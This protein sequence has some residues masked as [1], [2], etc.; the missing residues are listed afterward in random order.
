MAKNPPARSVNG[1]VRKSGPAIEPKPDRFSNPLLST[2]AIHPDLKPLFEEVVMVSVWSQAIA[3]CYSDLLV[4]K[5]SHRLPKADEWPDSLGLERKRAHHA[6][7]VKATREQYASKGESVLVTDFVEPR[8]TQ[9]IREWSGYYRD[10]CAAI[11]KAKELAKSPD[12]SAIMDAGESRPVHRWTTQT[13]IDLDNLAVT[14]H[15]IQMGGADGLGFIRRGLPPMPTNFRSCAQAVG[16]RIR[17]LRSIPVDDAKGRV[18][19][20]GSDESA[21]P[22]L[23]ENQCRVLQTMALFDASR[24]LSSKMIAEE[25]PPAF[26]LSV[27]TVRQCVGKL[28][29]SN[30]AERPEGNRRGAR[31]NTAGRRLVGKIA[32]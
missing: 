20:A 28:I 13:I 17:E 3:N 9:C 16:K 21:G 22:A 27:E 6:E 15:P 7:W 4:L 14:L 8:W 1:S 11:A 19:R 26:R 5:E 2:P 24:L 18:L 32:D 30:L 23:T 12:V 29:E 25:M 31:L 10:W